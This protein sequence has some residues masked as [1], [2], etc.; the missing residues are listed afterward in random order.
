MLSYQYNYP[1][2]LWQSCWRYS[3]T[4]GHCLVPLHAVPRNLPAANACPILQEVYMAL[5]CVRLRRLATILVAFPAL[6]NDYS[7]DRGVYLPP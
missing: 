2:L 3:K 1:R 4:G 5:L 7:L 6:V